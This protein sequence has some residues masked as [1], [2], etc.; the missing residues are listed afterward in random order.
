MKKEA[1]ADRAA[2]AAEKVAEQSGMKTYSRPDGAVMVEIA[3]HSYLNAEFLALASGRGARLVTLR[4]YRRVSLLPWPS[5]E[6][7]PERP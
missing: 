5:S 4:F 6:R 2:A 1:P 3:L 7:E